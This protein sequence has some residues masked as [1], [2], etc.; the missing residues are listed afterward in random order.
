MTTAT[1]VLGLLPLAIG[2]NHVGDVLYYPLARTVMGGLLASTVLTL[3]L[4]PCLY[5]LLEDSTRFV[6]NVWRRGPRAA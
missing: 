4:V 6:S 3:V 2:S 5:T 1:T